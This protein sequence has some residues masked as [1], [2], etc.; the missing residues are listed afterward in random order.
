MQ[1]GNT[2]QTTVLDAF[3]LRR[4]KIRAA[5]EGKTQGQIIADAV[6]HYLTQLDNDDKAAQ[7]KGGQK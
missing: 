7:P 3:T 4:L 6:E 1:D 5:M 2:K